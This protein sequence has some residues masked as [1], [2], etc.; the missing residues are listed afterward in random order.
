MAILRSRAQEVL[1]RLPAHPGLDD[2][3]V[4]IAPQP[5]RRPFDFGLAALAA[6]H[7]LELA[8]RWL[9]E[10]RARENAP[11]DVRPRSG[12]LL[13]LELLAD[14]HREPP[15]AE[16]L[17]RDPGCR[18]DDLVDDRLPLRGPHRIVEDAEQR[19]FAGRTI[20]FEAS[21]Q[22]EQRCSKAW[23]RRGILGPDERDHAGHAQVGGLVLNRQ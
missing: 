2:P 16:R 12:E 10:E 13:H 14:E 3:L 20:L 8:Y 5:Q 1:A 23:S 22:P 19:R 21:A 17:M 9:A 4:A 6:E 11:F 15:E 7:L 18:A